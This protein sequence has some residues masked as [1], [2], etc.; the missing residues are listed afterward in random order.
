MSFLLEHIS[1]YHNTLVVLLLN[2]SLHSTT[3]SHMMHF[4]TL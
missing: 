3:P 1:K 4:I 2:L